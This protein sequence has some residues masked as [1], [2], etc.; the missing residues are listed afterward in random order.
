[1]DRAADHDVDLD[2]DLDAATPHQ[3]LGFAGIHRGWHVSLEAALAEAL[4][5]LPDRFVDAMR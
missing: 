5:G 2:F 1:M 4:G 3:Q